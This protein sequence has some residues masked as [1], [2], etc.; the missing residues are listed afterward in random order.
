MP[1]FRNNS[2]TLIIV[3][4]EI[5]GINDH[6]AGVCKR[7]A[8]VGYD[9]IC[10]D[11]LDDKP[12]FDYDKEDEAY[13]YFMNFV[14]MES[15]VKRIA[16]LLRQ[17]ENTYRQIF[18]LGYSVGATIAW[19]CSGDPVKGSDLNPY[20]SYF[21][22]LSG[23]IGC[24][25]SRIREYRSFI[26]RCP[27]L[28]LF[29]EEELSFDPYELCEELS[30]KETVEV[31]ILEGRHGFADPY[32]PHYNEASAREAKRITKEFIER[33]TANMDTNDTLTKRGIL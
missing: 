22:K 7:L 17:E 10:P 11:L 5:Y 27:V 32:A 14:G 28:L 30:K 1:E 12:A 13:L 26:P 8:D 33:L 19:L 20:C 24:Y 3:L 23:I 4:H 9:V 21:E 25:G 18:L 6:I 16:F 29:P 2:D 31:H 15:S